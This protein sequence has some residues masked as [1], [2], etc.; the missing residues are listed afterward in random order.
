MPRTTK[1]PSAPDFL[2]HI[3]RVNYVRATESRVRKSISDLIL[4]FII[5]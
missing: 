5:K 4:F 2:C 3:S 1:L